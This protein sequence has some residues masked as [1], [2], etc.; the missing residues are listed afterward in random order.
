V[1]EEVK[2]PI[3]E[4]GTAWNLE[5]KMLDRYQ[6]GIRK[7]LFIFDRDEVIINNRDMTI[8]HRLASYTKC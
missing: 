4:A 6:M 8:Y 5:G 2:R 7:E 1:P 3:N